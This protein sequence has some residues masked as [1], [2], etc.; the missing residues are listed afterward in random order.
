MEQIAS[1]ILRPGSHALGPPPPEILKLFPLVGAH[2]L[3]QVSL[4]NM[5]NLNT[6]NILTVLHNTQATKCS[7]PRDRL[8][9]ILG[10]ASSADVDINY[11]ISAQVVYQNWAEMRIRRTNSLDI[12]SACADSSGSGDLP[13]WVPDLRNSFGQD[14][15]LWMWEH[16][17]GPQLV[18][19]S[20]SGVTTSCESLS[21]SHD[22]RKL[23][24]QG[25]FISPVA[26]ITRAG[27]CVA[28][29]RDPTDL[30]PRLLE[31]IAG[32]K[33]QVSTHINVNDFGTF[34]QAVLRKYPWIPPYTW[35]SM[36]K[37]YAV[38]SG[39]RSTI[40]SLSND[41]VLN[42]QVHESA[43]KNFERSLF[44]KLHGCQMFV[45]ETSGLCGIVAANCHVL[46]GDEVVILTG[47][48]TPFVIRKVF[49]TKYRLIT[50]CYLDG[51]MDCMVFG[52]FGSLSN[53]NSHLSVIITLI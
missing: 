44:S 27:D 30:K 7:D 16:L 26:L 13:S 21:F 31:I 33:D 4:K 1:Y 52:V 18:S 42:P 36:K 43:L 51:G 5:L 46:P 22:R 28:N 45:T 47:G 23:S 2:R 37:E 29:L 48:L 9:A 3:T 49:G 35:D 11:S 6:N 17:I 24:V 38:W 20:Y 8:Y 15:T 10:I 50:P 32:W 14:K 41:G 40:Q 34:H 25:I 53:R 39:C 12:L 19:K